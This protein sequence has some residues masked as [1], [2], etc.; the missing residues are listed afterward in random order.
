MKKS[1]NKSRV[2]ALLDLFADDETQPA[3]APAPENIPTPT[4]D[5]AEPMEQKDAEMENAIHVADTETP[6]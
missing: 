5:P 4:E 3:S 1:G 2:S 6:S